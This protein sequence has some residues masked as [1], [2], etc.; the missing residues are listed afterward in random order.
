MTP[1]RYMVYLI[2]TL[3]FCTSYFSVARTATVSLPDTEASQAITA[4][5]ILRA[6]QRAEI[7]APVFGTLLKAP[8]KMG[9]YFKAGDV[10]AAFDCR[11][12]D[13][14]FKMLSQAHETQSLKYEAMAELRKHGAAGKLEVLLAKSEMERAAAELDM[15][16]TKREDCTVHAPFNGF[17]IAR[18]A[19]AYEMPQAGHIIYSIERAGTPELSVILPATWTQKIKYGQVFSFTVDDTGESFEAKVLRISKHIDPVSQTFEITARPQITPKALSGM[20]GIARIRN[21]P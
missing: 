11:H 2:L 13:G 19:N 21:A 20:S 1:A 10:L 12:I 3:F 6:R 7:S 5:G 16:K 4:R 15:T 17:V 18:H 8:Y 9:Q 14:K